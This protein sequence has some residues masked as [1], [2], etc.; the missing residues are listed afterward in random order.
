[1]VQAV[2]ADTASLLKQFDSVLSVVEHALTIVAILVGGV[3]AYFRFVKERTLVARANLDQNVTA[4]HLDD[5]TVLVHVTVRVKN[6]GN[7]AIRPSNG[8]TVLVDVASSDAASVSEIKEYLEWEH[9]HLEWWL[10][11]EVDWSKR[12]QPASDEIMEDD[13]L[14]VYWPKLA[15]RV[16]AT[17]E[18]SVEIGAGETETWDMD[19]LVPSRV[20]VVAAFTE[21]ELDRPGVGWHVTT[22]CDLRRARAGTA[23]NAQP[24]VSRDLEA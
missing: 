8:S 3:W 12:P 5:E 9:Q 18:E 16:Y 7:F 24:T 21:L 20:S 2:P 4:I 6:V 17:T 15:V 22:L 14:E 1:M 11:D 19:F 23:P 10:P 13:L